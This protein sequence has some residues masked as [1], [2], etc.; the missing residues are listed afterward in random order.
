[1][2]TIPRVNHQTQEVFDMKVERLPDG[3]YAE[4]VA[5]PDGTTVTSS[6]VYSALTADIDAG[7]SVSDAIDIGQGQMATHVVLPA[8]LLGNKIQFK[9]SADGE[10]FVDLYDKTG[11]IVSQVAAAS[12]AIAIPDALIGVRHFQVVTYTDAAVQAQDAAMTLTI[13]RATV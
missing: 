12:R 9:V 10:T 3:S 11:T 7:A 2:P 5:L 6:S 13:L 4:V 8:D 1:M